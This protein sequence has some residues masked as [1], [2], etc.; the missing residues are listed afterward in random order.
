MAM[1]LHA[2]L[3][4]APAKAPFVYAHNRT[5][6]AHPLSSGLCSPEIAPNLH[7]LPRERHHW[8]TATLSQQSP[9]S[10]RARAGRMS[11]HRSGRSSRPSRAGSP[12]LKRLAAPNASSAGSKTQSCPNLR[13]AAHIERSIAHRL[14]TRP[15]LSEIDSEL[16]KQDA[17]FGQRLRAAMAPHRRCGPAPIGIAIAPP[18]CA[19]S[20]LL[21]G[22]SDAKSEPV[23]APA[24]TLSLSSTPLRFIPRSRH[25][26]SGS[27][28]GCESVTI[29]SIPALVAALILRRHEGGRTSSTGALIA[30]RDIR[31]F[32][33]S[34]SPLATDASLD[35]V[36][37]TGSQLIAYAFK[38]SPRL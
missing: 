10:D 26:C 35:Y 31:G 21:S 38:T 3:R 28:D 15:H 36:F 37:F 20:V 9:G 4:T 22:S 27:W 30:R 12:N 6:T 1:A 8:S 23:F 25:A 5:P 13:L 16:N 7:A 24:A 29:K 17:L 19:P 34:A 11:R 32:L 33:S 14:A 18:V 2:E